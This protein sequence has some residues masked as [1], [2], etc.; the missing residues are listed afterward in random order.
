MSEMVQ[1]VKKA[2]P[3]DTLRRFLDADTVKSQF[4]KS[5][6]E[7]APSFIASILDLYTSDSSLQKC[8]PGEI[9][10]EASKAALMKLPII[11]SLGYAY[12]VP[13]SKSTQVDGQ[14]IKTYVPTLI[15]G[16]K[17][18]IQM[19]IRTAQ[20]RHIN[21]DVVYEG[22]YRGKNKLT[23]EIDFSGTATSDKVVGY[24]AYIE[25]LNGF[26]KSFYMTQQEVEAYSIQYSPSYNKKEK[27]H[28]G[29]WGSDFRGMAIKT[30]LR[31]LLSKYGYLSVEMM[32]AISNDPD[33][34]GNKV[35]DTVAEIVS[36]KANSEEISID[37]TPAPKAQRAPRTPKE[38]RVEV[39]DIHHET[40][41][42]DPVAAIQD[43]PK[44]E[45]QPQTRPVEKPLPKPVDESDDDNL[46]T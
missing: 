17:G 33:H 9:V 45:E 14:W 2:S 35:E 24:F 19:A 22:E 37:D 46:W 25:L 38:K 32:G 28:T 41:Q 12:I 39:Q 13:F 18:L 43:P 15:V 42:P 30:V 7:N 6:K 5:M 36:E 4:E 44:V 23:G 26:S 11:K 34:E 29:N 20:Y 16:Y 3:L 31:Q 40:V 10:K 1:A 27:K 21:A 8:D